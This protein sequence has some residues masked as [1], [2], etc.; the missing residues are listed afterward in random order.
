MQRTETEIGTVLRAGKG[1]ARVEVSPTGMCSHCELESTCLP[2]SGGTRIIEVADP[3]GVSSG[4]KVRI[5]LSSGSYLLASFLAYILPLF[6][7]LAA[8]LVGFYAAPED[9][10][11][12]YGSAGAIVG[13]AAGLLIS[14]MLSQRLSDR[15][16]LTPMITE[17]V[18]EED[19]EEHRDGDSNDLNQRDDL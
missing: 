5:E 4:Q 2:A 1:S 6:G 12:L 18:P 15:G 7:L 16:G 14:R 3:I 8:A 19:L 13:L 10:S 9:V 17:I 11:E